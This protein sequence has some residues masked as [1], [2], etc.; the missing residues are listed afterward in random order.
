M[1]K[2]D[3]QTAEREKGGHGMREGRSAHPVYNKNTMSDACC[4]VSSHSVKYNSID[5]VGIRL[6]MCIGLLWA[7]HD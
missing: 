4:K 5:A 3:E 1:G 2:N 7:L 6:S